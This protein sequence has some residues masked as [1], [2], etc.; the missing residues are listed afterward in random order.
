MRS[1]PSEKR[2]SEF[3][4]FQ[5]STGI[6]TNLDFANL[7]LSVGLDET[8]RRASPISAKII[9]WRF[10]G[11]MAFVPEGQA[12]ISQARSVWSGVWTFQLCRCLA[13]CPYPPSSSSFVL[14]WDQS[15]LPGWK[16]NTWRK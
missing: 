6:L 2:H 14:D 12:D 15:G 3:H 9:V 13:P 1:R 4:L 8:Y 16:K 7:D 5:P 10:D 11:G